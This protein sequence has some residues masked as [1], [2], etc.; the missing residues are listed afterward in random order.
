[1]NHTAE[2]ISIVEYIGKLIKNKLCN[3]PQEQMYAIMKKHFKTLCLIDG[4]DNW[5]STKLSAVAG[6]L[7]PED[8]TLE[9]V[10]K[11]IDRII[12]NLQKNQYLTAFFNNLK[13]KKFKKLTDKFNLEGDLVIPDVIG[14]AL[15]LENLVNVCAN[16][17]LMYEECFN[18]FTKARKLRPFLKLMPLFAKVKFLSIEKVVRDTYLIN[19]KT[20]CVPPNSGKFS[21]PINIIEATIADLARGNVG[22]AKAGLVLIG[23]RC[24]QKK[25]DPLT[26]AGPTV[27]SKD[28]KAVERVF[29]FPEE[30]ASLYQTWNMDFCM[31]FGNFPYVITKLLVPRVSGY[32][33]KPKEY[34]YHRVIALYITL[35]F[36]G[37]ELISDSQSHKKRIDWHDRE[38][39]LHWGMINKQSANNYA[40]KVKLAKQKINR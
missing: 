33:D 31:G 39:M 28:G 34:I 26:G 18:I 40:L 7:L 16:D 5:V 3:L 13:F 17:Y 2:D 36:L 20:K 23:H 24:G 10:D 8:I 29:P 21:V 30:W 1:L 32:F 9:Q 35:N 12:E 22:N 11:F 27:F 15:V 4:T 37:F 14:F 6:L 19:H 38:L 25:N